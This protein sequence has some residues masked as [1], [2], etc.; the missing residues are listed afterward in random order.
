M[1]LL[2]SPHELVAASPDRLDDLR[3]FWVVLDFPPQPADLV[4][5]AAVEEIGRAPARDIEKLIACKNYVGAMQESRK[6]KIF[7]VGEGRDNLAIVDQFAPVRV[8]N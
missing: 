8:E 1:H 6:E 7:S 4:V 5:D 2:H 3:I